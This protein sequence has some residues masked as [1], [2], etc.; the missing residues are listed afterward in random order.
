MNRRVRRQAFTLIEVLLVVVIMAILAAT[1]VSQFNSS[2]DDAKESA[3]TFNLHALRS[4]IELYKLHHNGAAPAISADTLPQLVSATNDSGAV[5]TP[6]ASYPYG[7][8]LVNGIPANPLTGSKV[9]TPTATNPP[10]G[11]SGSGG[12]LYHAASGMIWA[13][14][15]GFLTY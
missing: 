2:T 7:P 4:Q 14:S 12:W 9:V 1:V 15:D 13:D 6:G 3:L 8:Y 10:A 5:G 11:A